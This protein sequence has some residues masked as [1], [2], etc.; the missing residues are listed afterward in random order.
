MLRSKRYLFVLFVIPLLLS[1]LLGSIAYAQSNTADGCK[2]KVPVAIVG[3]K[4]KV[5]ACVSADD[6]RITDIRA[7]GIKSLADFEAL[8]PPE[9]GDKPIVHEVPPLVSEVVIDG[10]SYSAEEIHRFDGQVLRFAVD[11]SLE[12]GIV[13]AFTTPEGLEQYIRETWGIDI[14]KR[15][16]ED[17]LAPTALIYS[18]FFE[19]WYY[20]GRFLSLAHGYG[21][22]DL[23]SA[24][25]YFDNIISSAQVAS[26]TGGATLYDGYGFT[27]NST[28]LNSGTNYSWIYWFQDKASSII[29]WN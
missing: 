4:G 21:I 20:G 13:Y 1:I 14:P 26:G 28:F 19:H 16:Q 15:L 12:K 27:G 7:L 6:S 29:A 11:E 18:T 24:P 8:F 17:V 3:N 10:R 22:S 25:W 9:R 23:R 2:E 5:D